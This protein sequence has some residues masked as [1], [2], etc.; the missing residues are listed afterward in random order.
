ML[1]RD[2]DRY[3]RTGSEWQLSERTRGRSV[4]VAGPDGC[5]KSTLA[6]ALVEMLEATGPVLHF[7][8][9]ASVLPRRTNAP[10]VE[11]YRRPPYGRAVS[12][13]K[14]TYLY[15]DWRLGWAARV[16]PFLRRGGSVVIERGCWDIAVDPRRYRVRSSA[17]LARWLCRRVPPPDRIF[18][19]HAPPEVI[20][21][22]KPELKEM[23]IARQS[24]AWRELLSGDPRA[25]W[26]DASAPPGNVRSQAARSLGLRS[27]VR[28]NVDG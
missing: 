25:V 1:G 8:Q 6:T 26:L 3:Q 20:R 16:E 27:D 19:L 15:A 10:V 7:H 11:P 18:I 28:I 14:L 5:G 13:L 12:L 4:I 21:A 2:R 22:R 23:E 24:E 9:R 17:W